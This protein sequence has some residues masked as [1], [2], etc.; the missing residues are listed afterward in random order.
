[1]PA[2]LRMAGRNYGLSGIGY[3]VHILIPAAL[4]SILFGLKV[5]WVFASLAMVIMLGLLVEGLVFKT[6]ER[7]TIRRWGI[8]H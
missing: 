2:T 8:Q 1:M 3:V 4:P 6:L 5:G 7:V